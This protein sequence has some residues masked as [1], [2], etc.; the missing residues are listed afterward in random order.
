MA[1]APHSFA[2]EARRQSQLERPRPGETVFMTCWPLLISMSFDY[3]VVG[4]R[5]QAGREQIA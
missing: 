3:S 1:L 2:N 5:F 4:K